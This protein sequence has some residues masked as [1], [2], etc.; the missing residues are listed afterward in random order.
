MEEVSLICFQRQET[1]SA[2]PPGDSPWDLAQ[3]T[4]LSAQGAG[5]FRRITPFVTRSKEPCFLTCTTN[6]TRASIDPNVG[7]NCI[8]H[9]YELVNRD[10]RFFSRSGTCAAEPL[11]Y[12]REQDSN[13][14]RLT[15]WLSEENIKG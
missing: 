5:I 7:L 12:G 10:I 6:E 1:N 9:E 2:P 8:S 3:A 4:K 14:A 15:T 13:G 11:W